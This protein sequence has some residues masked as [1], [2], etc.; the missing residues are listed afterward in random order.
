MARIWSLPLFHT[1]LIANTVLVVFGALVGTWLSV[2]YARDYPQASPFV[3]VAV[4][5]CIGTALSLAA[6]YLVLKAAFRPLQALEYAVDEVRRGDLRAR[7]ARVPAGDPRIDQLAET[8]N[9]MLDRLSLQQ[10]Q[11]V[12]LS[13]AIIRA[14]EEERKRIARDLHDQTAQALTSLLLRLSA[15]ESS[16]DPA[17]R[18]ATR[19][20]LALTSETLEEVRRMAL[21]LRP[22]LL[23]DLGLV[24]ALA[25]IAEQYQRRLGIP[26]TFRADRLSGRL[27]AEV[28]LVLYRIAQEALTNAAKHAGAR[29]VWMDLTLRDGLASLQV[30][31][32]GCGF[33][34]QGVLAERERGLGL[35]GMQERAALV[36]GALR[37]ES[38][39]GGGSR[40]A[41]EVS[42]QG[43]T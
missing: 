38:R 37:L 26:V 14:Q 11:A 12:A 18:G 29:Q 7:V 24:P 22:A 10:A 3:L 25:S 21:E 27:G 8:V 5:V 42:T 1:V 40:V 31:D 34:P 33:D 2:E 23:D 16:S 15:L 39:P 9:E 30:D 17:V 6:N 19:E 28:E 36:G 4:F 35:F 13:S 32:D 41:V 20:L 43:R